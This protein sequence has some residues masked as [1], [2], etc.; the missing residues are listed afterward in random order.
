MF[1]F[2][3]L[4]SVHS[5]HYVTYGRFSPSFESNFTPCNY[6]TITEKSV[7]HSKKSNVIWG[8]KVAMPLPCWLSLNIII[9][10]GEGAMEELV[11]GEFKLHTNTDKNTP[12]IRKAK[13]DSSI[14]F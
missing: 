3:E 8:K 11:E 5:K 6:S 7:E 1:D 13:L 2:Q 9:F 14:F 10:G 12:L 4:K